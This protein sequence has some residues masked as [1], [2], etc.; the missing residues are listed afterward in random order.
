MFV[1]PEATPVTTPL[2]EP[3]VPAAVLLL[4]QI[5]PL[6]PSLKVTVLPAAHK[7]VAPAIAGVLH[8]IF[9]W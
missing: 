1:V 5:P 7:E 2:E 6:A 9:T 8:V 3:I 4:D